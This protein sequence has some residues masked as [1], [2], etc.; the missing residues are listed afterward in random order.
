MHGSGDQVV[1]GPPCNGGEPAAAGDDDG[2]PDLR[3]EEAGSG[4]AAAAD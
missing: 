1:P 4:G 2:H 3:G